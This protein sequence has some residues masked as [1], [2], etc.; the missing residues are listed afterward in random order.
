[1]LLMVFLEVNHMHKFDAVISMYHDQGLVG[2]KAI[3]FGKGVNF[4]AGLDKVR[5][6]PDH[7][8]AFDLVGKGVDISSFK[9]T[10][11]KG[12]EVFKARTRI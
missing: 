7:G 5:V 12:I 4:T 6:S 3:S 2:F 9:S 10:M 8:T 11:F 1:M